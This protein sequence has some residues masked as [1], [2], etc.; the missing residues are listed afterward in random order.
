MKAE[1]HKNDIISE[2][3]KGFYWH[4][5]IPSPDVLAKV[6]SSDRSFGS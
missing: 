6:S 1:F 5:I 4:R 3:E 2:W